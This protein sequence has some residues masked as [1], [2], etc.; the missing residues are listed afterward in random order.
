MKRK[1]AV[2]KDVEIDDIYEQPYEDTNEDRI[3]SIFDKHIK[4]YRMKT[5]KSGEMLESE[6]YPLWDTRSSTRVPKSKTSR[7]A[8]RNL[9]NKNAVKQAV[10]LINANFTA[11]VDIWV[12]LTYDDEH[13]PATVA[14]AQKEMSRYIRRIKIYAEKHGYAPL[15]YIYFTEGGGDTG[16]RIHHH[17][18]MNFP[19]RDVA[20][21]LWR[22]G[23]YPRANRLRDSEFKFE[24]CARYMSKNPQGSKRWNASKNLAKPVVTIA[25]CRMTRKKANKIMTDE[26]D[27]IAEFER[28]YPGYRFS[29]IKKWVSDYV[30]GGYIYVRMRR[31]E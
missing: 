21:Q 7:K 5:I 2:R 12:H 9:N 18:V 20:E 24:G 31:K 3:A 15:K 6:I 10:R 17:V 30:S 14:D 4:H 1:Y 11:N 16:K 25:D 23:P 19:D 26:I 13:L 22:G 8:Q 27:V 29:D 28:L